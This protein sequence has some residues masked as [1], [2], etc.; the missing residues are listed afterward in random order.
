MK[1]NNYLKGKLGEDIAESYL[2]DKG[3][4]ILR[5]NFKI[6]KA[7]IDIIAYKNNDISFVEV[8]SRTNR[9]FGLACEAVDKTKQNKIRLAAEYFLSTE[10]IEY[11]EMSFDVIEIY[12]EDFEIIHII[13]CF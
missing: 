2:L 12:Y 5:K 4:E 13:D 7:E 1:A 6:K 10:H 3:Y 9:D 11:E 8:K